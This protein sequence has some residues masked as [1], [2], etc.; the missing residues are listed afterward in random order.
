MVLNNVKTVLGAA[1]LTSF[2]MTAVAEP[3]F[4]GNFR[5]GAVTQDRASCYQ[6]PAAQSKY[7]LG[8]ECEFYGEA[9]VENSWS[10]NNGSQVKALVMGS[11]YLPYGDDISDLDTALPQYYIESSNNFQ[12]AA[13]SE[14]KVWLGKRYYRRHDV[15]ILDFYYWANNGTGVGIEDVT[16]AQGK[17]AYAYKTNGHNGVSISSHDI[18]L[19][20]MYTDGDSKINIGVE[21]QTA[22]SR[23]DNAPDTGLQFHLLV[24]QELGDESFSE[25]AF[26]Y[27]EG[28]G[29]NLNMEGGSGHTFRLVAQA[30]T[31]SSPYWSV[32]PVFV[33]ENKID[34]QE[35]FSLGFRSIYHLTEQV[36]VAFEVGHD[37]ADPT[38][39]KA[40]ILNKGTV[41]LM[42]A[43]DSGFWTRPSFRA[44]MT[45]A[46][47]N[48]GGKEAGLAGGSAGEF[49]NETAGLSAG[50]QVEAT[51]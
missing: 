1:L 15:H 44:Y 37:H 19:Y 42:W 3:E 25:I 4:S 27:G 47:W 35:W 13:L 43:Q 39:G 31:K 14:A 5:G 18:Q 29:A 32:M 40:Q 34:E 45:W 36:G 30:L 10:L 20:D 9:A 26:Q 24:H 48:E 51:W 17:L 21:L 46:D 7:R 33:Y 28:L 23:P 12:G 11:G 50:L 22:D 41:A 6:A 8:N 49:G 2:S 38:D 16:V